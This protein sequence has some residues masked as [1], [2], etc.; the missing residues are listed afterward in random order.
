MFVLVDRM[1]QNW[2]Q[3]FWILIE[4]DRDII[5]PI[6]NAIVVQPD[7]GLYK[8]ANPEQLYFQRL[9]KYSSFTNL[10]AKCLFNPN[11]KLG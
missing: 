8:V 5:I 1:P 3:T 7:T 6:I 9:L 2:E 4:N 10:Q 11:T